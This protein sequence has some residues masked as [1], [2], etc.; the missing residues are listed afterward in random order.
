MSESAG[1]MH[2]RTLT[3]T[4]ILA[5]IAL[6]CGLDSRQLAAHFAYGQW[7]SNALMALAFVVVYRRAAPRLRSLMKYGVFI[8]AAGEGLFSLVFGMYEYRLENVPLYVPPGHS[9]MYAAV[10]Y[11]VREPLV[12]K[13]QRTVASTMLAAAS[14]TPRTGCSRRTTSTARCARACSCCWSRA[15]RT[16]ACSS[17]PVRVVGY[18]EQWAR[19][20]AAGSGGSMRSTSTPGCRAATRRAASACSTSPSTCSACSPT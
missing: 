1:G 5:L 12:V 15:T 20:S 6:V 3:W 19:A 2:R 17:S 8:G 4:A 7:V 13:H 10:Y 16:R 9:L 14:P 18:L 11:F